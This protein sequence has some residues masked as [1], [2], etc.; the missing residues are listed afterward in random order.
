MAAGS[1]GAQ[2]PGGGAGA[3]NIGAA[4]PGGGAG[5]GAGGGSSASPERCARRKRIHK[6]VTN[7]VLS[8]LPFFDYQSLAE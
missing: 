5:L 4:R 8:L 1:L 2:G 6:V 7:W 3:G